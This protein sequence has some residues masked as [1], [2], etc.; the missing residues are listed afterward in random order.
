M[1]RLDYTILSDDLLPC[2]VN[3]E[4]V[5]VPLDPDLPL[6]LIYFLSRDTTIGS[7]QCTSLSRPT[8]WLELLKHGFG[9]LA[10]PRVWKAQFMDYHHIARLVP[11]YQLILPDNLSLLE[12]SLETLISH[13]ENIKAYPPKLAENL[14]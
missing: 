13:M 5:S 6:R 7:L 1:P 14:L 11:A 12:K 3:E 2:Q 8:C 4:Q 9:E 10:V